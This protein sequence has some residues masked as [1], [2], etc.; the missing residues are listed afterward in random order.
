MNKEQL[1]RSILGLNSINYDEMVLNHVMFG[2]ENKKAYK[3]LIICNMDYDSKILIS[4][5]IIELSL[6]NICN[7]LINTFYGLPKNIK[8]IA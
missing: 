3:D 1:N 8:H 6:D 7:E 2:L 4:N 5:E